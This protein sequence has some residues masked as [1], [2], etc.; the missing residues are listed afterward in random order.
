MS[1]NRGLLIAA[2]VCGLTGVLAGT[3]GAHGL[4][5]RLTAEMLQ[6]YE[7]GVHYHLAH[8]VALLGVAIIAGLLPQSRAARL[9]GWLMVAG[10]IIFAG[11][12]YVL[13]ISGQKWL[14][15]ITPFGGVCF[16]IGWTSLIV[17]G[18]RSGAPSSLRG[19]PV[20]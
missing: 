18:V 5:G 1:I 14:G 7:V 3:F 2:G 19:D 11:S 6:T 10:V 13:V 9:A 16:L 12:L 15:M 4:K 17:A 20:G 8:A